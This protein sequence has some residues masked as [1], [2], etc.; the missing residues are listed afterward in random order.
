VFALNLDIVEPRHIASRMK[1][2]QQ[3][4]SDINAI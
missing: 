3:L 4:L 1:L 2:T